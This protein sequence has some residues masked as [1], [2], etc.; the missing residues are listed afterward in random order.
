[1]KTR[2]PSYGFRALLAAFAVCLLAASCSLDSLFKPGSAKEEYGTYA[3]KIRLV[4]PAGDYSATKGIGVTVT[5]VNT[6]AS[7]TA[8]TDS[9]G[10]ATMQV[11]AGMYKASATDVRTAEGIMTIYNGNSASVAVGPD[12]EASGKSM[13]IDLV[14]SVSHQL[15]IKELYYGGCQKDDGSGAYS[16]DKYCIIYNNSDEPATV[17]D[18]CLAAVQPYNASSSTNADYD[19]EGDLWYS[20]EDVSLINPAFFTLEQSLTIKPFGQIVIAFNNANDNTLTYSNSVDLSDSSYYVTYDP[21]VFT[22][23]TYHPAPSENIPVSHYLKA[24]FWAQGNAWSFSQVSPGFVIFSPK[25]CTPADFY[26]D[27]NNENYYNNSSSKAMLR[28]KLPNDWVLDAVEVF[29]YGAANNLKRL[30][31]SIDAGYISGTPQQGYTVYRNVDKERT[32]ALPENEGKLV[33]GYSLGTS[34]IA[35]GS[36][37]PSG[38]DAEASIANGAEIYY[39]D[40]NNST[41]DFHQ[42]ARSSLRK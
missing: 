22:N 26:T 6:E 18:L 17:D 27:S 7:Y 24:Y 13:E 15:V 4:Y 20:S 37:D 12:W 28:K 31:P 41:N 25:D 32:E 40:T 42:R 29:L 38:I 30:L 39:Q 2:Y 11:A 9:E 23:T 3:V 33:Y 34:D 35:G 16:Y 5:S 14:S 21:S 36:T 19:S 1:M 8:E 10:V